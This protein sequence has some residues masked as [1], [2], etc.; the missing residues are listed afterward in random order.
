ML[1]SPVTSSNI[2]S[3]GY[4]SESGTLEIEF[5]SGSVY[6][7]AGVPKGIYLEL[8]SAPSHGKYFAAHIKNHY[9]YQKIS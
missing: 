4:H 1:R 9:P 7:Y 3:I 2:H 8:M 6:V 5:H